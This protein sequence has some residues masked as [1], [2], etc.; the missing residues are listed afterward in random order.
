[1]MELFRQMSLCWDPFSL[2]R[3]PTDRWSLKWKTMSTLSAAD[4]KYP[5]VAVRAEI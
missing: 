2:Q 5:D 3:G 1:M 4:Q